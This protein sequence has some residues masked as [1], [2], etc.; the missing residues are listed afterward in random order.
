MTVGSSLSHVYVPG[1]V[2]SKDE[3]NDSDEIEI[4]M[5]I[6]NE[7]GFARV[8]TDLPGLVKQMLGQLLDPSD[9]DRGYISLSAGDSCV[10]LVNNLGGV[11][12]LELSAT[13][14]EVARQL[15]GSYG[16]LPTRVLSGTYMTSLNGLGFSIT[17]L[18]VVNPR[19]IIGIDGPAS[20]PGWIP[21]YFE[22]SV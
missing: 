8:K 3:L 2:A 12:L 14:M 22:D 11:S 19:F 10:L 7:E 21:C 17:L 20:A 13:T 6:H 5:G 1:R 4:G 15:H 9:A 16:L 18:K